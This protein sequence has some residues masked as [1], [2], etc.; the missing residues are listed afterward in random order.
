M[1]LQCTYIDVYFEISKPFFIKKSTCR[2]MPA[3]YQCIKVIPHIIVQTIFIK[4]SAILCKPYDGADC[5]CNANVPYLNLKMH[6]YSKPMFGHCRD[7]MGLIKCRNSNVY[8]Y[9]CIFL[10]AFTFL[11][12]KILLLT[13]IQ[14]IARKETT[15]ICF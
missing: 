8:M 2:H 7:W 5:L 14:R 9:M 6:L 1:M 10:Y 4:Y 3:R 11:C 12:C 13:Y 15:C